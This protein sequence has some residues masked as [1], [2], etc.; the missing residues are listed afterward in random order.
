MNNNAATLTLDDFD[1]YDRWDVEWEGPEET[2]LIPAL[3][4]IDTSL[5]DYANIGRIGDRWFVLWT[6]RHPEIG[7][8]DELFELR[9]RDPLSD[10]RNRKGAAVLQEYDQLKQRMRPHNHVRE[11]TRR[12]AFVALASWALPSE[13]HKDAGIA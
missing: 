1:N 13:F 10:R 5:C 11:I 7:T 2:K 8:V 3:S 6:E 4:H 9:K 12:E